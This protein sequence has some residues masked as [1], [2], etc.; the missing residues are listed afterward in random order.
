MGIIDL[1]FHD[2]K[3]EFSPHL[4]PKEILEGAEDENAEAETT[5]EESGSE[6]GIETT[7]ES[8]SGGLKSSTTARGVGALIALAFLVGVGVLVR[9]A[10]GGEEETPEEEPVESEDEGPTSIDVSED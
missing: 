4:G 7:S 10:G 1:H 9:K 8:G 2:S 5:I 6:S 3:I